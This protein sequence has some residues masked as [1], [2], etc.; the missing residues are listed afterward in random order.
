M[1]NTRIT[2]KNPKKF[3]PWYNEA[4]TMADRILTSTRIE[5]A[6]PKPDIDYGV[7]YLG[8]INSNR[9]VY[10]DSMSERPPIPVLIDK[11]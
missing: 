3:Q 7:P 10:V 8:V 11:E 5:R 4:Q 6:V 9:I 1:N 2:P